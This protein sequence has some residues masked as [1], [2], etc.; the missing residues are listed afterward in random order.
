MDS[1]ANSGDATRSAAGVVPTDEAFV[2][3]ALRYLDA[4]TTE[5]ESSRLCDWLAVHAT[6]RERYVELCATRALLAES[7]WTSPLPVPP[8]GELPID[9]ATDSAVSGFSVPLQGDTADGTSWMARLWGGDSPSLPMLALAFVVSVAVATWAADRVRQAW[10]PTHAVLSEGSAIPAAPAFATDYVATLTRTANCR[11]DFADAQTEIGSRLPPSEIHLASGVAEIVFDQGTRVILEGPAYFTPQS[12]R[13]GFLRSGK[14]VA[15]VPPRADAFVIQT[16]SS[17][18]TDH[19]A[20]YGLSVDGNGTTEL[21][22]FSGSVD[23]GIRRDLLSPPTLL[24]YRAG[25]A[26]RIS[27]RNDAAPQPIPARENAF[28]RHVRPPELDF[29]NSLVSYWNFD[30]QGG[31]A[32]DAVGRND[33]ALQGVARTGG[34][35]GRGAI[36]FGDRHGQMVNVGGG[37]G[38]FAFAEGVTIEA[39]VVSRW[40]GAS[41]LDADGLNYDE[42]FR[43][44]DGEQLMLFSLQNDG[45]RNGFAEPSGKQGHVL[46]F[47][48]N[49]GGEYRELDMP[50]DGEE[51]RPSLIELT[52]G[53]AHHLVATYD[54]VS[55]EK[56]IYVDGRKRYFYRYPAGSPLL[57]GGRRA[58]AIGNA[59]DL[60]WEPFHGTIDE[61]AI[62]R[63]AL[64]EAEIAAHWSRVQSG[65]GYFEA[66]DAI[67][68]GDVDAGENVAAQRR[69]EPQVTASAVAT[70]E[71]I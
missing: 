53:R 60:P 6:L 68:A 18:V 10:S 65:R 28:V 25:D 16:P 61:V 50:L 40:D 54:A 32:G 57:T 66:A 63:A 70:L 1:N 43:K 41:N 46:S 21:H 38:S 35:I 67:R 8:C 31:P 27:M 45:N 33:G 17:V 55:G 56:A 3:L 51:G 42:I 11:W 13:S 52:D 36:E 59:A 22:A 29:P 9:A 5:D 14:L 23:V 34:L 48:I 37:D 7:V 2:D 39:L 26:V 24:A 44:D 12:A 64:S 20:E 47:G 30:E 69:A 4:L 15:L 62:Y 49:V 71:A 19:G 58:A